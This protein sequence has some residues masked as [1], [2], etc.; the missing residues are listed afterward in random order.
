MIAIGKTIINF[1]AL[2]EGVLIKRYKR[3]LVDVEL[4]NGEIVTAIVQIQ[5]Q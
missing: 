4:D 3:F 1:P 5:D 2:K